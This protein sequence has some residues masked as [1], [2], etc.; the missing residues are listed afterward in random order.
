MMQTLSVS[1][2]QFVRILEGK[3]NKAYYDS[4][5]VLTIGCGF[6]WDS[7][8]FR[9]WWQ[10]NRA[11]GVFDINAMM[12]DAEI[13]E[14]L[15][16]VFDE[17]YGAA[18]ARFFGRDVAQN[19]FDGT[20]SAVFNMGKGSLN[21]RWAQAVNDNDL[22]RGAE[23][24]QT[25]GITERTT[26]KVLTGLK[27]RRREEGELIRFGDYAIAGTAGTF[28]PPDPM[29]DGMLMR[30]ERG[31]AVIELQTA[32]QLDGTYDGRI[33]GIFGYGTEAA[34]IEFQR[35]HGLTVDGK[36]GPKTLAELQSNRM[37]AGAHETVPSVDVP[38]DPTSPSEGWLASLLKAVF[39][40]LSSLRR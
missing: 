23:L 27:N 31:A 39:A 9:R 33:D 20:A 26:H 3:R 35:R 16:L 11:G 5:R 1:G 10:A 36:A 7:A 37:T 14:V 6:T 15:R 4:A 25:V 2:A 19:V 13:D 32:L 22:D 24:L 21:W 40:V 29:A 18:V 28:A 17:E 30:G 38:D 12:T 34:V 8:S